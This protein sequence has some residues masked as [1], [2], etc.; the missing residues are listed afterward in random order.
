M[1]GLGGM[2]GM[3]IAGMPQGMMGFPGGMMPGMSGMPIG[4]ISAGGQ[5]G[6]KKDGKD[7]K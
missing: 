4:M 2:Q 6:V 3:S 7:G 1:Q 5:Q